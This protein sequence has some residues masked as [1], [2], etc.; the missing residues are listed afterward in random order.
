MK[1]LVFFNLQPVEVVNI[2]EPETVIRRTYPNG[3]E[4]RLQI[5]LAEIHSL[6]GDHIEIL[7]ASDRELNQDEVTGAMSKYL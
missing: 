6:T 5:R 1:V 7:V 3:E 4:A 2:P